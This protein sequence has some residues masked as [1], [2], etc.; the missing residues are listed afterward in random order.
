MENSNNNLIPILPLDEF[1]ESLYNLSV[2]RFMVDLVEESRNKGGENAV[3]TLVVDSTSVKY[4]SS[5]FKMS[6]ILGSSIISIDKLELARPK[7]PKFQAIYFITPTK[8][9]I[10]LILK[11]FQD[12]NSPQYG[13]FHLFFT[14]NC[15]KN[16]LEELITPIVL[17]HM[18][19][20]KVFNFSFLLKD[21]DLFDL[22]QVDALKVFKSLESKESKNYLLNTS[23]NLFTVLATL[24]E[25]PYI[26][27]QKDSSL[28]KNLADNIE[29][30]SKNFF[31][32]KLSNEQRGILMIVDRT[33]DK[34]SP[35]LYN[36]NYSQICEDL[37]NMKENTVEFDKDNK[38]QP[39]TFDNQDYLWENI[40]NS[41]I[42][43]CIKTI[44]NELSIFSK[45]KL[46]KSMSEDMKTNN[47]MSDAIKGMKEY[48]QKS[49]ILS[50][51]L[52]IVENIQQKI[53]KTKL[54]DLIDLQQEIVTGLDNNF[55]EKKG[56]ETLN[57]LG[58]SIKDFS[59]EQ[60]FR[61]VATL[62]INFSM[63][64][65]N[66][67]LI[68]DNKLNDFYMNALL[69]LKYLGVNFS[70]VNSNKQERELALPSD[71]IEYLKKN[72][73]N[74]KVV[75]TESKIVSYLNNALDNKTNKNL[76]YLDDPDKSLFKK[77]KK[78]E[79][80]PYFILFVY[81]GLTTSE[82]NALQNIQSNFKMIIGSTSVC[83]ATSYIEQL[84]QLSNSS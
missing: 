82:I 80:K 10:D 73:L 30:K 61:I 76:A 11:D 20:C 58:I 47:Q 4:L 66:L 72:R 38:K 31:K 84:S 16:L 39:Y 29:N 49:N 79:D 75:R 26:L 62:P 42:Y 25:N 63:S 24:K 1:E 56:K 35:F 28:C 43:P 53:E 81:G 40:K 46:A 7:F 9:S 44:Q 15:E 23:E 57:K 14:H 69:N 67:K 27:Y 41:H 59:E 13:K 64:E 52:K 45:S 50:S 2:N 17:R 70:G 37:L 19:T 32:H 71:R 54:N 6:D 60:I 78:N 48:K 34:S 33:L 51:H 77:N 21:R 12:E 5:C 68:I 22:N 8:S 83:S 55:E 65:Q 36:Y 18:I 74:Y 3:L